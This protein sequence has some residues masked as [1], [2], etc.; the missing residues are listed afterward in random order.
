MSCPL[1]KTKC[2]EC[3]VTSIEGKLLEAKVNSDDIAGTY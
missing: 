2:S 1:A 3:I